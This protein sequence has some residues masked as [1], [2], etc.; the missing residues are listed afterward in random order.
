MKKIY[1]IGGILLLLAGYIIWDNSFR[2][3]TSE[4]FPI[5]KIEQ[6]DINTKEWDVQ[7]VQSNG[8]NIKVVADGLGKNNA[9]TAMMKDS[10]LQVEQKKSEGDFFGGF[11][12]K[13]N[14]KMKIMLPISYSK[15]LNVETQS[16]EIQLKELPLRNLSVMSNSGD[17]YIQ[18]ITSI[19]SKKTTI[20]SE[21]GD[22]DVSFKVKPTNLKLKTFSNEVDNE[23]GRN[24]FGKG[25][26]QLDL[27]CPKGALSIF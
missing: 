15:N 23:L 21:T 7:L 12:F 9:A 4:E 11:S 17:I 22:I 19:E 10:I 26:N 1:L 2:K 6:I 3:E 5:Q 8:T 18:K 27:I 16:G 14:R 25:E 13:N 20:K 24:K